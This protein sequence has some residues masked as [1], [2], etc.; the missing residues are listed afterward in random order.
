MKNKKLLLAI[1]LLF[2]VSLTSCIGVNSEFRRL[3]SN[4]LNN[5]DA[6]FDTEIEFSIGP[7]GIMLA[8]LFVKF[9]DTEQDV[10]GMLNQLSRVQIGVFKNK[11]AAPLEPNKKFLKGLSQKMEE[12]GWTYIVKN[13]E[14]NEFSFVFVRNSEDRLREL[15]VIALDGDELVITEVNGELDELIAIAV[16]ENGLNFQ[17]ASY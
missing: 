11:S 1:V 15:F 13:Y 7:A 5:I 12:E 9:A 4:I 3:R 16:R 8:G 6:D 17:K 10:Q 14:R 2:A